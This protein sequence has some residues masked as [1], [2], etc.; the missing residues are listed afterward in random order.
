M[1][2]FSGKNILLVGGTSGIGIET[3]KRLKEGNANLYVASRSYPAELA[4]LGATRFEWDVTQD[5]PFAQ[6]LPDTLHG[7]VYFPGTITLKPFQ[8]FVPDQF[9]Q[10][11]EINFIGAVKALKAAFKGLKKSKNASVVLY[12]TV[13]VGTGMNF[14]SSI[15]AAKGALEGFAKSV[16]AEWARSNIRVNVL[17]PS[18]TDTPL[19]GNLLSTDEKRLANNQRHPVGRIGTATDL[20]ALTTLLLSDEG[21]WITGQTI[22]VDGGMSTLKPL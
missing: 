8:S 6:E 19:A 15:A 7:V 10:D 21:S 17:A 11:L 12:S 22:G 5:V 3:A 18:L 20:A 16:A 1:P 13:A 2:D 9:R 14:H 4:A